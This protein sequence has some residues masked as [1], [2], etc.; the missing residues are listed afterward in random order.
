[1][2]SDFLKVVVAAAGALVLAGCAHNV[3]SGAPTTA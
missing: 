3:G 2:R 1:M